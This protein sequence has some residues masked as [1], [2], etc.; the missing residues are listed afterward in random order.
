MKSSMLMIPGLLLLI[1]VQNAPAQETASG[2]AAAAKAVQGVLGNFVH[3]GKDAKP[4]P[5]LDTAARANKAGRNAADVK[6]AGGQDG[7]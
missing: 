1:L 2:N 7:H 5:S 6:D 4:A 3:S